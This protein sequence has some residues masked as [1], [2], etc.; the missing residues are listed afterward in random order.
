MINYGAVLKSTYKKSED[1]TLQVRKHRRKY[2]MSYS[3]SVFYHGFVV[4]DYMVGDRIFTKKKDISEGTPPQNIDVR[5]RG[6]QSEHF[7]SF[8]DTLPEAEAAMSKL[9]EKDLIGFRG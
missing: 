8:H 4:R 2:G 3:V 1:C 6:S 5:L 9:Y 7:Y